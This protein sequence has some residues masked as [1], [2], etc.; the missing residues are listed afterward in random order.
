MQPDN[1]SNRAAAEHVVVEIFVRQ[2]DQPAMQPAMQPALQ[3]ALLPAIDRRQR[4]AD[5]HS[6]SIEERKGDDLEEERK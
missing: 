3:P 5:D 2:P 1:L 4:E 6:V